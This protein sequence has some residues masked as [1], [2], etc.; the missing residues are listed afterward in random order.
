[1]K[2]TLFRG[3]RRVKRES[4]RSGSLEQKVDKI[5]GHS[6]SRETEMPPIPKPAPAP[7]E[8]KPPSADKLRGNVEKDEGPALNAKLGYR[9]SDEVEGTGDA[10][11]EDP[12][13][14]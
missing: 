13:G 9:N 5:V 6:L 12:V 11:H 8:K 3:L 1:V 10:R 4:S 7:S 14:V 2:L